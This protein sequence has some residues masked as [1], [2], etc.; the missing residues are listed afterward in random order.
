MIDDRDIVLLWKD[1]RAQC[2]YVRNKLSFGILSRALDW[3]LNFRVTRFLP[4]LLS[5]CYSMCSYMKFREEIRNERYRLV[6][7]HSFGD[8]SVAHSSIHLTNVASNTAQSF[9]EWESYELC[10]HLT[11]TNGPN[12]ETVRRTCR[13]QPLRSRPGKL[14]LPE[15]RTWTNLR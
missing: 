2:K 3:H 11:V 5:R 14:Q 8:V 9:S 10:A 1:K 12:K 13:S 4:K 7:S 15:H 6:F